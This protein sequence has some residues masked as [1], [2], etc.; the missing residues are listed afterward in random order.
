[1]LFRSVQESIQSPNAY[2]QPGYPANVMP[3]FSSL[4]AHQVADLV[5]F[6]TLAH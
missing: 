1:M 5:A 6:L 2:I 3:T 4:S